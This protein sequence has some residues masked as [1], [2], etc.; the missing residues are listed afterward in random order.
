MKKNTTNLS[1]NSKSNL[2]KYHS[3]KKVAEVK[4]SISIKFK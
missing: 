2:I 3:L 4:A 1:T